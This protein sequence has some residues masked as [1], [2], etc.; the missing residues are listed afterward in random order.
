MYGFSDHK[1]YFDSLN[2]KGKLH[3]VKVPTMY[4][5]HLDDPGIDPNIYPYEEFHS[6][7]DGN[8][9]LAMT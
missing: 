3:E 2:C 1:S 4:F 9:F 6:N 8:I 7:K 5:N